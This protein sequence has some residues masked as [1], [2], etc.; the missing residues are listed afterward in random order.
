LLHRSRLVVLPQ[1]L[2][3]LSADIV[4]IGSLRYFWVILRGI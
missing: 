2:I 1:F 4:S 3:H